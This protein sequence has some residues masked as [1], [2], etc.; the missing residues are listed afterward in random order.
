MG[1]RLFG[2]E[3]LR[4][5]RDELARSS[6]ESWREHDTQLGG[7]A[8]TSRTPTAPLY[9]QSLRLE[10]HDD[11]NH[12]VV[13]LATRRIEELS[14]RR[15]STEE[16]IHTLES[17][18]PGG[19]RT[20]EIEALIAAI[21]D[22]RPALTSAGPEELADLFETFEVT[23]VYDKPNRTLELAATVTPELVPE[24]ENPDRATLGRSGKSS[25]AGARFVPPSDA[26][27]L[28]RYRLAA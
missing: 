27:I 8:S 10:E 11:A 3:R 19:A 16:A 12:L 20:A 6:A 7:S 24:N 13:A 4:L 2:P 25:I 17:S 15:A 26:R 18:R 5:L 9:R 28:E 21:L 22:L 23:A 14:F 1:R